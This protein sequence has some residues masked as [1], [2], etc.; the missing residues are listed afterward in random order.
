MHVARFATALLRLCRP[1]N[2]LMAA[3]AT[4]LG[5]WCG[6][7]GRTQ[8]LL[9]ACAAACA[10][11]FGNVVNDL[12]DIATDRVS[13]AERPLVTGAVSVRLARALAVLLAVGALGA[14]SAVSTRHLLGAAVPLVLLSVYARWLKRTPVAGNGTVAI[15]VAYPILFGALGTAALPR[16]LIP[17]ALAFLL[18]L[19]RE[20]VKDV[21]DREGDAAAGITTTAVLPGTAITALLAASSLA[22]LALLFLPWRLGHLGWAY[23][24]VC[25]VVV[26][27]LHGARA[28][29]QFRTGWEMRARHISLLLKLEMLAGLVALAAGWSRAF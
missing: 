12:R 9:L 25:A 22:Y 29:L 3:A 26:L 23:A 7:V 28:V 18:N 19:A 15:L 5:C 14:A 21:Q 16:L 24:V 20:I 8:A 27:P 10:T 1:T 2:V 6:Q 13:H 11:A 4:V 17:A